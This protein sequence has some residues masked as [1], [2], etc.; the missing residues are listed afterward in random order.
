MRAP[1][2]VIAIVL[3]LLLTP[4]CEPCKASNH[5]VDPGPQAYGS[6]VGRQVLP[7]CT[8]WIDGTRIQPVLEAGHV[9]SLAHNA[10]EF[11][12]AR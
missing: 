9:M 11:Q 1:T 4:S 6:L 8:L 5:T 2:K 3:L 12:I 7:P 10:S